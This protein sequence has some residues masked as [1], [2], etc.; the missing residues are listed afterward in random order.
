MRKRAVVVG[1][2]FGG[3]AAAARLARLLPPGEW[4]VVL[5]DRN[6][7]LLFYPLLPEVAAGTL[8]PR[9]VV[10]PARSFLPKGRG[11][12]VCAEVTGLDLQR[13]RVHL[14]TEDEPAWSMPY[15]HLVLALGSV[16]R[17]PAVPGLREHGF[18]LKT[19][20]DAARLRDHGIGL[21]ERASLTRDPEL[22]REL[23]RVVVVGANFTGVELAGEYQDFLRDA[24]RAY[25]ELRPDEVDV[26][27]VEARSRILPALPASLADYAR[28][29]LE[30]RGL[31]FATERT[32]ARVARNGAELSDGAWLPS[33]TVVWC[34]GIAPNPLV[35]ATEGLP[36]NDLG[37]IR[38]EPT[39]RV[40]GFEN[41]WA[42]GDSAFV[43]T[44]SGEGHPATAQVASRQGDWAARNVARAAAGK[45]PKPFAF[46]SRGALAALGCRTAVA[47]V[48]GLKIAGFPAW[49]LY[50]TVY[51]LKVPTFG[52]K[53]SIVTDWTV[54]LAAR[55]MPVQLGLHRR[56][57]ETQGSE[58][59][60]EVR[61]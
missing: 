45:E 18:E 54:D 57:A 39:L 9:H 58:R 25:P 48:F 5:V 52:R 41:V 51:L 53:L 59:P 49:F 43:P 17:L 26:V 10:V 14:A 12:F 37:Y 35:A 46:R 24:C 32:V 44:A 56:A 42:I 40:E 8:E 15:D 28:E 11:R 3:S 23:L 38:T 20:A 19:L 31:R 60:S 21:L 47:E 27:V 16:T 50:R 34:A 7:Y 55:Q 22:R 36:T 4:E 29:H 1:A 6:N 33:R 13:R 61:R 2:G 30:R